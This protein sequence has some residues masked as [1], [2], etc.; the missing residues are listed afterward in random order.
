MSAARDGDG[1][2]DCDECCD[3]GTC[4]EVD[5]MKTCV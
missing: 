2:D 5:D 3:E 1:K 4:N